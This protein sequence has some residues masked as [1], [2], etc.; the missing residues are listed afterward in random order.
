MARGA[1]T[2]SPLANTP[3]IWLTIYPKGTTPTLGKFA[4]GAAQLR[5]DAPKVNGQT[6]YWVT[7]SASDPTNGGDTYLRWQSSDGQWGELHGYNMPA[8]MIAA[9][10]LRVAAGVD[11]LPH[12]VPLPLRIS[13]L[14]NST[15]T[16]E[17]DLDRPSLSGNGA[18][19]VYLGLTVD[20]ASVGITVAPA[21][22]Q[23]SADTP[24]CKTSDQLTACVTV[25]NGGKLPRTLSGGASEIL[26]HITLLG[27]DPANWTTL[28]IQ[29]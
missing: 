15:S 16:T 1:V 24:V 11:F 12:S 20:G 19:D 23:P 21:S 18:W 22:Q 4:D 17:A 2:N 29:N 5:V 6:A 3:I 8:N 14:P 10:L 25:T 7:G 13:G 27:L 9:N 28:V 26:D